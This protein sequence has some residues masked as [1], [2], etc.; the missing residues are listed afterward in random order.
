MTPQG[1]ETPRPFP[2]GGSVALIKR[3]RAR[4]P[5]DGQVRGRTRPG[6]APYRGT[7]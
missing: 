4:P 7:L 6:L 1:A 2:A 5:E 3:D